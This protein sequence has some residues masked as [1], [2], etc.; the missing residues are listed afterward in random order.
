MADVRG[1]GAIIAGAVLILTALPTGARSAVPALGLGQ[2]RIAYVKGVVINQEESDSLENGQIYTSAA[3]GSDER[4]LTTTAVN[5]SDPDWEPDGSRLVFADQGDLWLVGSHGSN[6]TRLTSGPAYDSSPVWSPDGSRLAFTRW[7]GYPPLKVMLIGSE[8]TGEREVGPGSSPAWS[9]DGGFLAFRSVGAR[10]S[11]V[12]VADVSGRSVAPLTRRVGEEHASSP[13]WSADGSQITYSIAS[14]SYDSYNGSSYSNLSTWVAGATGNRPRQRL[15]PLS[16]NQYGPRLSP[17]GSCWTYTSSNYQVVLRCGPVF[18][19]TISAAMSA[20][21][22]PDRVV[23]ADTAVVD[24]VVAGGNGVTTWSG[25][26]LVPGQRYEIV[27]RGLYSYGFADGEADA[28]CSNGGAGDP[29]FAPNRFPWQDINSDPLDL[30][31][32]G[33]AHDDWVVNDPD[34]LG[35]SRSHTYRLPFTASSFDPISFRT[36]DAEPSDNYGVLFVEI[37][38]LA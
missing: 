15:Q 21:W 1:N 5:A 26:G 2:E 11:N 33:H 34:S 7:N 20:A 16:S 18:S 35:C 10:Q 12:M 4:Q 17:D 32:G 9:P 25:G 27:A 13:S 24:R 38:R 28:E 30:L 22:R 37:R 31:V 29:V 14:Y 36:S 23:T 8:G 6:L 19:R 3:D